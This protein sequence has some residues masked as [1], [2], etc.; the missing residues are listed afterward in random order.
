MARDYAQLGN[1]DAAIAELTSSY[2]NHDA[3][4]LW[5]FTD[6]ELDSLRSDSRFQRLISAIGFVQK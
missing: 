6:P 4:V 3:E 2:K 5:M 1:Q